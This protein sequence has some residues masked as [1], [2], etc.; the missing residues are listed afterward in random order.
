MGTLGNLMAGA[1]AGLAIRAVLIRL[2]ATLRFLVP[3]S[4]RSFPANW[5][6]SSF[7]INSRT[8]TEL[9]LGIREKNE[10]F[11][12]NGMI[13]ELKQEDGPEKFFWLLVLLIWFLS[14]G[15]YRLNIK[16]TC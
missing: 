4:I 15:L 2:A 7:V 8:P 3:D 13:R 11:T 5:V 1:V 9:V 6:E 16:T 14:V 12:L 10:T